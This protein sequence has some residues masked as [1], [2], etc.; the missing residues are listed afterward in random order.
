MGL[1]LFFKN[2]TTCFGYNIVRLDSLF[3]ALINKS[4]NQIQNSR[5]SNLLHKHTYV[6][7]GSNEI[8]GNFQ[9]IEYEDFEI[10]MILCSKLKPLEKAFPFYLLIL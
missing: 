5:E 8:S 7:K 6:S 9:T 10:N 4:K 2:L 3:S 1:S